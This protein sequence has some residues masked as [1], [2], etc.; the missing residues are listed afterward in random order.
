METKITSA[1]PV[2]LIAGVRFNFSEIVHNLKDVPLSV[3]V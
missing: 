3:L 1:E 2:M